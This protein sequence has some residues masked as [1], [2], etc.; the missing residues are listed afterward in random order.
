[1]N[2]RA[3]AFCLLGAAPAI[4]SADSI[5]LNLH[6]EAI[7]FT[8]TNELK[9]GGT[10]GLSLDAG[11]LY[12]EDKKRLNDTLYH[13]GL[14]VSGEN[15]SQ[16]GTFDIKLGG[17]FYYAS[18]ENVDLAALAVG[19]ALRFS[20]AHRFGIGA[21]LYY[22]PRITS[23]MDADSFQETGV[24]IDYQVLPQAFVYVGYRQIEVDIDNGP[25]NVELEDD[26]HLGFK[27]LF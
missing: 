25:D 27:M 3:A 11:L 16:S 19:G 8:Y 24:T 26:A 2:F 12:S 5:D 13:L 1:M 9:D 6:D 20:P 17:R 4:A 22:A 7:R 10:S 14:H 21:H 18:P 15:W 23:Y